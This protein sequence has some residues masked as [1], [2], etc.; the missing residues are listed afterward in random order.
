MRNPVFCICKNKGADQV[1]DNSAFVLGTRE[2]NPSITVAFD[3]I[4]KCEVFVLLA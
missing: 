2:Y 4:Q 1:H 3:L